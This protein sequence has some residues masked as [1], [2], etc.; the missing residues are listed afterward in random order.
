[1]FFDSDFMKLYSQLSTLNEDAS[2]DLIE[3]KKDK[4]KSGKD[5]SH[6]NRPDYNSQMD[7][8]LRSLGF[9]KISELI[10][11]CPS[12]S[13]SGT[14]IW[15]PTEKA[16]GMSYRKDI[17]YFDHLTKRLEN[18]VKE[19]PDS[20][21]P[22]R[23]WDSKPIQNNGDRK[24]YETDLGS[25]GGTQWR[26]LWF[27]TKIQDTKYFIFGKIF[28]KDYKKVNASTN[29]DVATANKFYDI[30]IPEAEKINNK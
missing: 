25:Q 30:I 26:G 20:D 23:K 13:S 3:G 1:M 6:G 18:F 17:P 15:V 10:P 27:R 21:Y 28:Y 2:L 7:S 14:N 5:K 9:V 29:R 24:I 4:N 22:V 12:A 19:L 11:G 8:F 16:V